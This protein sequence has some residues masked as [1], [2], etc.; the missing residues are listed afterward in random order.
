MF[1]L[2]DGTLTLENDLQA[3]WRSI[4]EHKKEE[5]RQRAFSLIAAARK[6]ENGCAVT[7]TEA[8]RKVRFD[9]SQFT[10]YR[11][12]YCALNEVTLS[13]DDVVRHRCQ[14]R[15]CIN[16]DHL[17][18]GSRADNK[19]DDWEYWANGIDWDFI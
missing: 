5:A 10:A 8:V 9:G 2:A 12:V 19:R 17:E 14:N 13:Y 18:R 6:D 1:G 11:F 7:D 4:F 15:K 3:K 16:P